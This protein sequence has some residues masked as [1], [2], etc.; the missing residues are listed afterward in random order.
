MILL[1]TSYNCENYIEKCI[2]SIQNQR[3]NNFRCF[4]TDDVSTDNTI[5]KIKNLIKNDDRFTIIEN[6]K[7]FYQPGNYDQVIRNNKEIED[8]EVIIEVDGDDWLPDEYVLDRIK[9][10]YDNP[11]VWIANG[12]FIYDNGSF[13][14]SSQQRNF[15]NLRNQRFTA[16]HI[17]TW[18]AFLWRKIL[19]DD[20]KDKNGDYWKISGDLS[21]MLPMLEMSGPEHYFFMHDINYV[22]NQSNPLN[23]HKV[24]IHSVF[25]I[26][27]EIRKKEKYQRL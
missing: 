25:A 6:K 3:L 13:G 5:E 24:D 26:A 17:R 23:D 11:D 14:F 21:F 16:S 10:V 20:L 8:H 9:D 7:K 1:T 18:R 15:D 12:S 4:I 2:K 19:E 22:Y 27:D